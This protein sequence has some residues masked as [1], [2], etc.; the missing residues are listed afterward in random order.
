[1]ARVSNITAGIFFEI[2]NDPVS[3]TNIALDVMLTMTDAYSKNMSFVNS[4]ILRS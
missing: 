3:V 2:S 4:K 1:M